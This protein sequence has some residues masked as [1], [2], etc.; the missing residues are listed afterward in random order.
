MLKLI[1]EFKPFTIS[2]III[3]GLLFLQAMTDLALPDYM[4]NI[5]NIGIQQN[6]IENT[7]P[8]VMKVEFMEKI[9]IFLNQDEKRLLESSYRLIDKDNLTEKEYKM[10]LKKYPSLERE[11][12]YVLDTS[13]K[14]DIEKM[15]SFL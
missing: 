5:V 3:I 13:S 1:K 9:K 7:V 15:D 11:K 6:G 4:S 10:Y 12:L 8:E 14:E 2:I